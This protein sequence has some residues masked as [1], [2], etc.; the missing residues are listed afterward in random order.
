MKT[1]YK[2]KIRIEDLQEITMPICA[3]VLSVQVIDDTPYIWALVDTTENVVD[4]RLAIV[5]TGTPYELAP[6]EAEFVGTFQLLGGRCV[7]HLF[8]LGY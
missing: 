3:E 4:R 8:D 2:Y 1:I 7:F 5:G 6:L